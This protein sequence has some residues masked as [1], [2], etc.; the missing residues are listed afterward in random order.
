MTI[1]GYTSNRVI[2]ISLKDTSQTGS[3]DSTI[4][5]QSYAINNWKPFAAFSYS[6]NWIHVGRNWVWQQQGAADSGQATVTANDGIAKIISGNF[7]FQAVA[8]SIDSTGL[9]ID[10][11]NV[12]NGVFKNIPYTYFKQ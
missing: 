12:T 3:N 2:T 11:V 8:L 5:L 9:G 10:T 4:K 7:S 1:T 6:D